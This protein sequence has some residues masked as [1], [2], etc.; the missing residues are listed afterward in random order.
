MYRRGRAR[1]GQRLPRADDVAFVERL[2]HYNLPDDLR[3]LLQGLDHNL[4]E[5]TAR[6]YR[7]KLQALAEGLLGKTVMEYDTTH[8]QA[9]G[10]HLTVDDGDGQRTLALSEREIVDKW[11]RDDNIRYMLWIEEVQMSLGMQSS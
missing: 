6:D 1:A 2:P 9:E 8:V 10:A 7:A 11:L 5:P 4:D 3:D